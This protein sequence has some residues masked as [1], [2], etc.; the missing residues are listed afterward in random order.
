MRCSTLGLKTLAFPRAE[1]FIIFKLATMGHSAYRNE[2]NGGWSLLFT[3]KGT[4]TYAVL[5]INIMNF[6]YSK[7]FFLIQALAPGEEKNRTTQDKSIVFA[8]SGKTLN[9]ICWNKNVSKEVKLESLNRNSCVLAMKDEMASCI[10]F[11][12][13]IVMNHRSILKKPITPMTHLFQYAFIKK[14]LQLSLQ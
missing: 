13:G 14:L 8:E 10:S 11:K 5:I 2:W 3:A 12:K 7:V 4:L 9:L 6:I 1:D